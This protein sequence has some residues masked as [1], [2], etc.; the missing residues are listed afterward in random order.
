MKKV[1]LFSLLGLGILCT[2]GLLL[3]SAKNLGTPLYAEPDTSSSEP[4]SSSPSSSEES[5]LE[6][7]S[8]PEPGSEEPELEPEEEFECKV[9]LETAKHGK[10]E[11]DK[12]EGHIGDIVTINASPDMFYLVKSLA[13]NG[14]ALVEDEETSGKF[15]FALV[16]GDNTVTVTFAI[17]QE[18]FGEMSAMV[19]QAMNGDWTSLFSLRNL[20]LI[21]TFILNG[22]IL[23]T[24]IRYY[25][26]DKR[27][28]K[29]LEN[30]VEKT[31]EA[32]LPQA[33][34]DIII[35][36]LKELIAPYFAKIES[37]E[38]ETQE[39]MVV[40]C[41]CFALMQEDTPEAKIAIT[42]EL[43]SLKS[44]DKTSISLV[45]EKINKFIKD[46]TEK[47]SQIFKKLNE[48]KAQNEQIVEESE[49]STEE[50]T[51]EDFDN[52]TQI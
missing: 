19:D 17:D 40:L 28:E 50:E 47:T 35:N 10:L 4:I 20:I 39:T 46:Q 34:R 44:S 24:I 49:K 9:I 5:S 43:A 8:M 16:E 36:A 27:L 11:A 23:L 41:R 7:S 37:D 13:V 2:F 33:T 21:V 18:L 32:V 14:T 45:E 15:T 1:R 6:S 22:G 48:M 3:G 31:V 12:L 25:I 42:K 51:T 52:G 30:R 38:A 29:K 26:K